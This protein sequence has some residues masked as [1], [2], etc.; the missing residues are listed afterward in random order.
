MAPLRR[1]LYVYHWSIGSFH[2][3][4]QLDAW[5]FR[6]VDKIYEELLEKCFI[7]LVIVGLTV[8]QVSRGE[9]RYIG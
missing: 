5:P 1:Q 3:H 7:C 4:R 6:G 9:I 8:W 2:A